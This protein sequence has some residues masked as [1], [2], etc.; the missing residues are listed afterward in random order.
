MAN[1]VNAW[2]GLIGADRLEFPTS[3]PAR[4][5]IF[6]YCDQLSYGGGETVRVKVHT[7]ARTFKADV[8]LDS[9]DGRSVFERG[10]I[11]GAIQNTPPDAYAIGCGW[12]D[13]FEIAT[14]DQ[15]AS[16][17]YLIVLTAV[18]DDGTEVVGEACFVV[19]PRR[20][21]KAAGILL[22]LA[23]GTWVS[24]NDWGGA[25]A[26]RRV[27]NGRSLGEPAPRLS[28][29]R[30]WAKGFLR[31][32]PGAPRYGDAPDLPPH[33]APRYPCLEWSLTHGYSRHYA[34]A[35]WA[36]YER[37]F[38]HWATANG[39]H[40][41]IINQH[42]LHRHRDLLSQYSAIAV[43][44]HDE[45]W[46]WEMRDAIDDYVR[47]GGH[48]ARLGGNF[49]WQVRLEEADS[50]QVCH[51]LAPTDPLFG[52]ER[53]ER[54]TTYWDS[55]CV[56]RPGAATMGLT[57]IS[58]IYARYGAAAPR[59]SGG[60]TVYRP[61]HWAFSGTDLY[62]GDIFG[63]APARIATF[64]VDGVNYTFRDGLPYPTHVDG[65]PE[66]LEILAMTPAARGEVPR[67]PGMLNAPLSDV[68]SLIEIVP[69]MYP[70]AADT[71]ER[72]A[73]MMAIFSNGAGQVFN[74]GSCE[75]VA[76][77]IHRD[78]YVERVTRN[79]LDRFLKSK[80]ASTRSL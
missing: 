17:L 56:G 58:G 4:A 50:V 13:S 8:I 53:Q 76:G 9:G 39:Y 49:I 15:W 48:L 75:W 77:L 6:G 3:D 62:Y 25:N 72:G 42:D 54:T 61:H 18:A 43:V 11:P 2:N 44:G 37:P 24:Y 70:V 20:V 64:E 73:G 26:Y 23:T 7:T 69:P 78:Y 31:L 60:Y 21:D 68:V 30:P 38:V 66:T 55:Q 22:V 1:Q 32:P 40:V 63:G 29:A 10:A 28:L 16:G 80:L 12:A 5:E 79:V 33:A 67:H 45:Y 27:V 35:G 71:V 19:R 52:T 51:K 41:D 74:G 34:D 65:A 14:T 57:G 46:T 59:S 47:A 36:Y